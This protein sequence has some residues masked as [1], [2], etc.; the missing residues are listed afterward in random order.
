MAT[1]DDQQFWQTYPGIAYRVGERLVR[2]GIVGH[3]GDN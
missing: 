3:D 1:A 2:V